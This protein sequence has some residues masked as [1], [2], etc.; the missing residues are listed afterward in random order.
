VHVEFGT[1][2]KM[3]TSQEELK[4]VRPKRTSLSRAWR[5]SVLLA[6]AVISLLVHGY[7][8]GTDDAAIYAPGIE[9]AADPTLFPSGSEFFMHHAGLSLFPHLV[10][11]VTWLT[12][13][14]IQ[15]SMLLW[16]AFA[17]F[18]LL[19]AAYELAR[20][21]F[22]TERA[23]W[24]GVG[25]L[26]ALLSVPV[27]GTS[28]IISDSYLTAR[29]LSTP[30]V[31]MS[32]VC[33][34]DKRTRSAC[35]WLVGAFLVHP[36]MAIYGAG[37]GLLVAFDSRSPRLAKFAEAAPVLP[38]LL[39]PFLIGAH[40]QP[41]Q[42]AY[43]EVLASRAYFLVT[44]W[45]WWEWFGAFA[46]LV[47]LTWF[48]GL[49]L[50]S[51]LPAFSRLAKLLVGVGLISIVAALLLASDVDFAYLLRLQPMRSFH[52]IY[53]AFFILLGGLLGEYLLRARV[54]RWILCFGALSTG[55]FAVDKI[56]YPASPH[57]ERPGV[58]YQ[59]EWLSSFL[60]IREH[61][62]KDAMFA[63]D[64]EYLLKTGV[65][66]HG[67]RAVAERSALADQEKDSGAASVFPELAERW[68]VESAAQSDWAHVSTDRLRNL[69]EQYG[70]TWVL[71]ENPAPLDGL[72][73]PYHNGELRVCRILDSTPS[74][75][76]P[77]SLTAYVGHPTRGRTPSL[78]LV[79]R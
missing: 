55:M 14:S 47:L 34:L 26:A 53:V 67:F 38:A 27:A 3:M 10:A 56:A 73:C 78:S 42:G 23:R 13:L 1:T 45:H 58:R 40:L 16:F 61:T 19:W 30:L 29:S 12:H 18:L 32:T 28:L 17:Q 33:F 69:Q 9:K 52:L 37:V 60:W 48:T 25:L 66:L 64:P 57:I 2:A 24:G 15:W 36:Q 31:L 68:K 54:W 6:I 59:G 51:T 11:A 41:P 77:A 79:N 65:D 8:M 7:H 39:L 50:K 72:V 44:T 43:R 35:L 74:L 76:N 21:C 4:A 20:Q 75:A 71:L 70:V 5:I 22:Q 62:P 49:S 63:L 46:P